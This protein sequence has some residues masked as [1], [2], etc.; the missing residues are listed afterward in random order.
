MIKITGIYSQATIFTTQNQK[1]NIDDYAISQLQMLCDNPVSK[2]STIRIMPDVHPGKIATIGLTMTVEDRILPNLV[3]VDIGCGISLAKLKVKK[4]EFQKLDKIIREWVPS[5]FQIRKKVHHLAEDF[6][7]KQL[8]CYRGIQME[9]STLS[10]GTLGS[11]N[12]FIEVDKDHNGDYYLAVHSGSRH[13]GCEVTEY[14]LKKGHDLLKKQGKNIP[15]PLSYLEGELMEQY[16]MDVQIVQEFARLNRKIMLEE[17]TKRMKW[18][19]LDTFSCIHNYVESADTTYCKKPILRKGA[20]SAKEQERVIIPIHMKDGILLGRGMGNK[21]W[22]CSAPHG[23]GR[24]YKREEVK[25][26]FTVS[27]FKSQMK[28]I[29][30]SCIGSDTLDESP[31]AYRQLEDILEVIGD[32]VLVEDVIRPVYNFKAGKKDRGTAI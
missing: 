23:S 16:L 31:F 8:H 25:S 3:G 30:S 13:L 9:K 15:Y 18:K 21:N 28:G 5:G 22:N 10:L 14:Y 12:H 29:Y 26:H 2:N 19:I 6:D 7:Y 24:I 1:N 20:I 4:I 27:A 17:I 11:G 32:T